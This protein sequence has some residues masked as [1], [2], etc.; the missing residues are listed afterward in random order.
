MQKLDGT[1]KDKDGKP[2]LYNQKKWKFLLDAPFKI[3]GKCCDIMKKLPFKL[4]EKE[5]GRKPFIG[6]TT[7]ESFLRKSAYL[8]AGGCNL[9]NSKRAT[10]KPLSIWT[11]QDILQY[12]KQNN[13]PIAKV[14]GE[15]VQAEV[16]GDE[17]YLQQIMFDGGQLITTGVPRTGCMFCMFGVHLEKGENKFQRMKRTH[18]KQ[19]NFCINKLGIGEA[20]SFI[21]V[22]YG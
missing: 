5:T 19:Y 17:G 10:S 11:E 1:L 9:F 22:K 2:S 12:I 18:L 14:Y 8:R 15:V 13:L 20:L 3:S 16:F 21:G 4:Y 7:D 6:T